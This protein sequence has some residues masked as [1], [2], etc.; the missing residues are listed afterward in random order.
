VRTWG[1]VSGFLEGPRQR[2][3]FSGSNM[4]FPREVLE[5][6][7]GFS[8]GL[9]MHGRKIRLGEDSDLFNRLQEREPLFWYDPQLI[10]HHLVPRRNLKLGYR[11]KRAYAAGQAVAFMQRERG[12][13]LGGR[14]ELLNTAYLVRELLRAL[15]LE[16]GDRRGQFRRLCDLCKQVGVLIGS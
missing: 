5:R 4:A 9:G 3:G 15:L 13:R 14:V 2:Y 7:G 1:E 8:A 6:Y 16:R 12:E 10:V 11:L